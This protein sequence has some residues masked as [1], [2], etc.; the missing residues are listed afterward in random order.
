MT[1][2]IIPPP[3]AAPALAQ[4][5]PRFVLHSSAAFFFYYAAAA[6]LIPFLILYY[7]SL[8]LSASHIGLLTA[9]TPVM[10][11]FVAPLWGGLADATHQHRNLLR[12]AIVGALLAVLALAYTRDFTRL[13]IVVVI[14][15]LF[16]APLIPFID[17]AAMNVLGAR[18]D[19]YGKLRLWGAV[20][21]GLAAAATGWL[22]ERYGLSWAFSAYVA[23]MLLCLAVVWQLPASRAALGL[24]FGHSL[25]RLLRNRSWVLFLVT[26]VVC[27]MCL[28]MLNSFL[29]LYL[30]RMHASETLIGL[31]LTIATLTELPVMF[32][33][34]RLLRRW[35]ARSLLSAAMVLYGLRAFAYSFANV[36]WL[37]LVIQLL[38]GP[39]FSV[40]WVSGVSHASE[41]APEGLGATAQG[42]FSSVLIGLGSG[43]GAVIGGWLFDQFGAA[44]MFRFAGVAVIMGALVFTLAGRAAKQPA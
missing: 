36:P 24:T 15:A 21:W 6:A 4:G 14:Y 12:L 28:A 27:G 10:T 26:A 19:Q 35:G 20:G 43:L 25:R 33:A 39:T 8:G 5:L 9:I 17:N 11:L 2:S 42:M 7:E 44:A 38:H 40:L 32:F 22:V 41:L 34:D 13:I 18:R 1:R 29:L 3:E 23:L 31:S 16:T 30:S 37:V